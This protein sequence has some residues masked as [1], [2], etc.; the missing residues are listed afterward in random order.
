[1]RL[2]TVP[3]SSN[4]AA[5]G[6]D[7]DARALAVKFTT[8]SLYYYAHITPEQWAEMCNAVSVG[9]WLNAN[10]R[11]NPNHPYVL[12]K[13]GTELEVDTALETAHAKETDPTG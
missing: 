12:S 2:L 6:Y 5:M 8:G 13:A 4:V 3:D 9:K 1:M 11:S 10:I 7:P